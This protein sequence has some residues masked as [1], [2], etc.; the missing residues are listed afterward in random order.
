MKGKNYPTESD[1]PGS[2]YLCFG[3][4]MHPSPWASRRM[5]RLLD[6]DPFRGLLALAGIRLLALV[7][8]HLNVPSPLGLE[9]EVIT[10]ASDVDL[11]WLLLLRQEECG[12]HEQPQK[13]G[14]NDGGERHRRLVSLY[15]LS[16][17]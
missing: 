13:D 3:T 14:A 15:H 5:P 11:R 9:Q 8:D 16:P 4:F 12:R 17:Y 1:T 2:A 6:V 7:G 10:D